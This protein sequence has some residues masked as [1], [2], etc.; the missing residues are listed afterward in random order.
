[1]VMRRIGQV[2]GA[3]VTE[4]VSLSLLWSV[5]L[6]GLSCRPLPCVR[7]LFQSRNPSQLFL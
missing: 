5:A 6:W 4:G 3:G 2:V 7:F 1:M